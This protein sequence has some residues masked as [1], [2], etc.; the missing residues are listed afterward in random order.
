MQTNI[1]DELQLLLNENNL[2]EQGIHN[3]KNRTQKTPQPV[4]KSKR[5]PSTK[6]TEKLGEVPY[7]TNDNKHRRGGM[8]R[9]GSSRNVQWS[10][11]GATKRVYTM[12]Q[13]LVNISSFRSGYFDERTKK[14]NE[15]LKKTEVLYIWLKLESVIHHDGNLIVQKE[16]TSL[17]HFVRKNDLRIYFQP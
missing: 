9:L 4:R 11:E 3:G 2:I 7:Y 6:Q 10:E 15:F 13:N 5:L 17:P 1:D 14:L 12:S 16:P 8:S